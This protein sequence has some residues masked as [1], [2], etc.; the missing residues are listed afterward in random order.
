MKEFM[1]L[2]IM[3]FADPT[4]N[5]N[6]SVSIYTHNGKPLSFKT[7]DSCHKWI[8]SDLDNLKAYAKTVYPEAVAVKEIVCVKKPVNKMSL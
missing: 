2:I 5:G 7:A 6:D 3:F 8:W 4:H 1:I